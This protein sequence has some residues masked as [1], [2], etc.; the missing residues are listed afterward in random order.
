MQHL[1]ADLLGEQ[2]QAGL[3]PGQPGRPVRDRAGPGDDPRVRRERGVALRIG[4]L[5]DDGQV[6]VRAVQRAE[7]AVDIS[8]H[9]PR[10]AG[11]PVASTSTRGTTLT[12]APSLGAEV[13]GITPR[14]AAYAVDLLFSLNWGFVAS[15]VG[16]P[17]SS[18]QASPEDPRPG[19][20]GSAFLARPDQ[21]DASAVVRA[22]AVRQRH[23][24]VSG[25]AA[26][27]RPGRR[28]PTATGRG[29][30]SCG[31]GTGTS[32]RRAPC[33]GRRAVP[34]RLSCV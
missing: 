3:L 24:G 1:G 16:V 27:N 10:S 11:T 15:R 17:G 12:V 25:A 22:A 2:R 20:R 26:L 6:G 8:A 34:A 28:T 9:A 31:C 5:A 18:D 32:S 29:A 21:D 7:Q 19:R 14:S 13:V 23:S 4:A 30:R 33:R